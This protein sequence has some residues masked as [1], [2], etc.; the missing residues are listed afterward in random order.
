[1]VL[2]VVVG[3]VLDEMLGVVVVVRV[4]AMVVWWMVVVV[5]CPGRLVNWVCL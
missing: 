4:A 5:V 1:M 3:L 2:P